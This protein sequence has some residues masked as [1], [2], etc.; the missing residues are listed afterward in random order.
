M[1]RRKSASRESD[2]LVRSLGERSMR[3]DE[4]EGWAKRE[5][6][7]SLSA[8]ERRLWARVVGDGHENRLAR[9]I[10]W[11]RTHHR[12]GAD[13]ASRGGACKWP[14][15]LLDILVASGERRYGGE[16]LQSLLSRPGTDAERL[17][18][19]IAV[20]VTERALAACGQ[21]W[22]VMDRRGTVDVAWTITQRLGR[23]L[24]PVLRTGQAAERAARTS[25]WWSADETAGQHG[26]VSGPNALLE[27]LGDH[28]VTARVCHTECRNA[29]RCVQEFVK[30]CT[31]DIPLLR[32]AGLVSEECG[33]V[34]GLAARSAE[35]HGEGR[36]PLQVTFTSGENVLYKPRSL[37]NEQ[38]L[39][40]LLRWLAARAPAIDC[41]VPRSIDRGSYGWSAFVCEDVEARPRA[42]AETKR[43]L[44]SAGA[45]LAV[46]HAI[47]SKD[48]H[49]RNVVIS[50]SRP[51][52]LDCEAI[53]HPA[54]NRKGM[55]ASRRD[56][57]LDRRY[58]DSVL[59]SSMLPV[60]A[61]GLHTPLGD[62][63]FF[64]SCLPAADGSPRHETDTSVTIVRP[65]CHAEWVDAIVCGF[66]E[67]YD[68]CLRFRAELL[69]SSGPL[70]LFRR[71]A[72]RV[73][74]RSSRSYFAMRSAILSSTVANSGIR[75]GIVADVTFRLGVRRRVKPPYWP[76][77][78]E[79]RRQLL[80]NDVPWLLVANSGT[81]IRMQGGASSTILMSSAY[82]RARAR[83]QNLSK[84]DRERQI[85][86]I[87]AALSQ[88]SEAP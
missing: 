25:A 41:R 39:Y 46:A 73:L 84:A 19:P 85:R 37:S 79:E 53:V 1:L 31:S 81:R 15:L 49:R 63:S 22:E 11:G 34:V 23:V 17:A 65:S 36:C 6:R 67:A 2:V 33:S 62:V 4:R 61:W 71:G 18:A 70:A 8:E 87:R 28:A 26:H 77:L 54:I 60:T 59:G 43:M 9:R 5:W 52:V 66:R 69:A 42:T 48:L 80:A 72:T 29:F 56:R 82:A 44:R 57:L 12:N 86:L 14:A 83:V 27:L 20:V 75:W 30:R 32:A 3:L 51:V 88:L 78:E 35:T 10:E 74:F 13:G 55:W 24:E 58:S 40:E 16:L 68:V 45:L 47:G 64:G 7:Q 50:E 76:I 21:S 38:A